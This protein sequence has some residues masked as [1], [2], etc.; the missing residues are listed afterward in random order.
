M[1]GVKVK[2]LKEL[3]RDIDKAING[4]LHREM[5]KW[6][7]E[8]G[9]EFLDI[10]QAEIIAAGN[11]DTGRLLRSFKKGNSDN[12]WE[13]NEGSLTLVVGTNVEY[14][15]FVNDGHFQSHRFVPG[16]FR[17]GKF[18]YVPGADT[19]MA[20]KAKF[21]EG[22]HFWDHA[23]TIYEKMFYKKLDKKLQEYLNKLGR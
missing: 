17:G 6:L 4:E 10:V 22:S 19:G 7:E 14:A 11:V 13:L 16:V 9:T 1:S 18:V 23:L 15:S 3:I 12:V 8:S 20:L 2:G 21:V 5:V